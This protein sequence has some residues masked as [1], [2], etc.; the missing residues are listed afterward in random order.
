MKQII[1]LCLSGLLSASLNAQSVTENPSSVNTSYEG[2]AK[3][4]K[5]IRRDFYL[6]AFGTGLNPKGA[7]NSQLE[8]IFKNNFNIITVGIYMQSTQREKDNYNLDMVDYMVDYATKNKIKVY[9]HPLF[10]GATYCPEWIKNGTFTKA[11]LD[12]IMRDR[13]TTILTRYKNKVHYVD[14]VNEALATGNMT[15]D[16]EFDWRKSDSR[17]EHVWMNVMGMYQGRKYKFPQYLVDAFRIS[18]EVGGKKLK[19]VLNEYA[20]ATTKSSRGEAFLALVKAMKDEGIPVDDAGIQLHCTIRNGIFSESGKEP[21][22]FDAFDAML[23]KYEEAGIDVHITEFDI[24]MPDNPNEADFE[25]QGK[26]YAE[27]LKHA[28]Q[29]PAVKSFKTWGFTD[30]HAWNRSGPD[31]HPLLFDKQYQP[32]PAY[33]RQ[34]EMLKSLVLKGK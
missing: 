6:G 16:G 7:D 23:K 27:I 9:F 13:I 18:R 3:M 26:Y 1:I 14:V 32:K 11:E 22:D 29:S 33:I 21:F 25:L 12:K 2:L 30:K 15:A 34:A 10:G 5:K 24:Y 28:I 8:S 4:A 17:G 19:L 20:N 31:G